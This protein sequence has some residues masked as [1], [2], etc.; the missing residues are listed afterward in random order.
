MRLSSNE[1]VTFVI[2]IIH[3]DILE[4]SKNSNRWN[5]SLEESLTL[6][7]SL[8]LFLFLYFCIF[9]LFFGGEVRSIFA[10][11]E[12]KDWRGCPLDDYFVE[13]RV[14]GRLG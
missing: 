1:T 4:R 9:F 11:F 2:I 10:F 8:R 12:V 3:S 14:D 5:R 6:V 13:I 7:R